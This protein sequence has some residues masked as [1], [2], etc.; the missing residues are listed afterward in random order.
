M[1]L[2]VASSILNDNTNRSSA[3]YATSESITDPKIRSLS[4]KKSVGP[5]LLHSLDIYATH[6]LTPFGMFLSIV[7][8]AESHSSSLFVKSMW[9]NVSNYWYDGKYGLN[10][11]VVYSVLGGLNISLWS[12]PNSRVLSNG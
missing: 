5:P 7:T 4:W 11:T 2:G 3:L 12:I 10:N 9:G 1:R 8:F 6:A